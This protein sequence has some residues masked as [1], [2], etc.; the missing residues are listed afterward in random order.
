MGFFSDH[1]Q[2]IFESQPDKRKSQP[3]DTK[4]SQLAGQKGYD[5]HP[6]GDK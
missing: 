3:D 6:E 1:M 5:D 2:I 4:V